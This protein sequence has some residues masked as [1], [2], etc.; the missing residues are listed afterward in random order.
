[1]RLLALDNQDV[2]LIMVQ[3]KQLGTYSNLHIDM[4]G[5]MDRSVGNLCVRV[6]QSSARL[7]HLH[8]QAL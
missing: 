4:C 6:G 3:Q 1:M 8:K 5:I 7:L 2:D